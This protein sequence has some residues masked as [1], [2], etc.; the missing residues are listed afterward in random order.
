ME[1]KLEKQVRYLRTYAII[2]TVFCAAFIL[3]NFSL[4]NRKIDVECI[5]LAEKRGKVTMI[6]T[7]SSDLLVEGQ[8]AST[9]VEDVRYP[10]M[11]FYNEKDDQVSGL[12]FKGELESYKTTVFSGFIFDRHS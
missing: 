1:T 2:A 5:N 10:G 11:L 9:Q 4:Q 6:L 12:F 7:I 3:T 8:E